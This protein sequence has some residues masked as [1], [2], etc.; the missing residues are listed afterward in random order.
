[1]LRVQTIVTEADIGNSGGDV[2][3][4]VNVKT[5]ETSRDRGTKN[6]G[7]NESDQQC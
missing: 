7:K 2:I 5:V 1:M 3:S 4:L 6:S